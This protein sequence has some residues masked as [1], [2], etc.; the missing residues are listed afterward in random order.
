MESESE[1]LPELELEWLRRLDLLR[2]EGPL[3]GALEDGLEGRRLEA[4]DRARELEREDAAMELEREDEAERV[5]V[6]AR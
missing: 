3:E 4:A 5:R 1:L 6:L 2:F